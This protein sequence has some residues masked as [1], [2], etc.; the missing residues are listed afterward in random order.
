M[1]NE[2]PFAGTRENRRVS[3][4]LSRRP[5]C[6]RDINRVIVKNLLYNDIFKMLKNIFMIT[7]KKEIRSKEEQYI[8]INKI[9]IVRRCTH[10]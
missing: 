10:L 8:K 3:V 1:R 6:D 4:E 2:L 7:S 5:F 9:I